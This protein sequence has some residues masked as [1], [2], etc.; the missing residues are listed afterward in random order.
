[1]PQGFGHFN[2]PQKE[3]PGDDIITILL[4]KEF[5]TRHLFSNLYWNSRDFVSEE[6][7]KVVL[8]QT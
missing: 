4:K 7:R 2:S 6:V 8:A 1:M 3:H 5:V